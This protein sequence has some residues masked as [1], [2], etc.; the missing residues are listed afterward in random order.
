MAE[1]RFAVLI[2]NSRFPDEPRLLDLRLPENDVDGLYEV[3]SSPDRGQFTEIFRLK[4]RPSHEVLRQINQVLR[5]AERDDLV[6]IY[7]SGHGKLNLA[8]QLHLATTDTV[9]DVLEATSV[10]VQSIR[11]FVDV[12]PSSKAVLLLDCCY[13]GAVGG[14]FARGDVDEQLQLM[15]GG[16]GTYIMTAST[17]TQV[18]IENESDQY[19]VFTKHIIE[20]IQGGEADRNGDGLIGMGELYSYVHDRVLEEGHR[21]R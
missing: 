8:G 6:L 2:A 11:N 12:S 14:A 20:G 13:S 21:S 4:N 7:Y 17:G 10:P 18:A 5:Q 3:L 19:G 9:L 15:S 16:R 1:R